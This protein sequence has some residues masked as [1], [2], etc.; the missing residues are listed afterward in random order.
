[1]SQK[2]FQKIK[3]KIKSAKE[4]AI[5]SHFEQDGD[6]LGSMIALSLALKQLKKKNLI[7]AASFPEEYNWLIKS[8]NIVKKVPKHFKPDVVFVLDS[9]DLGRV[10][11]K[12]LFSSE[13]FV[14]NIDHHMDNVHFGNINFVRDTS[15]VGEMIFPLLKYLKIKTTLNI[16]EAIYVAIMTDTGGFRF[17]NTK[18]TTFR[19]AAQLVVKGVKPYEVVKKVYESRN[20][21]ELDVYK[22]AL[23]NISYK[24]RGKIVY[25]KLASASK[26][27][28]RRVIDFIRTIK[29][30][31]VVLVF[32][33]LNKDLV[34]VSLRSK[35]KVDVNRIAKIFGGGGH[36]QAS[37]C[38]V[39]G[40][41]KEV[42][43]KVLKKTRK[44]IGSRRL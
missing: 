2:I 1:M 8:V 36:S 31:E 29:G 22:E 6:S 44:A 30:T 43:R 13:P 14:I 32:K 41:E 26:M 17:A 23:K 37:G 4:I 3:K 40:R 19:I 39:K 20:V 9:S 34:K 16:A 15:S 11:M 10:N 12:S 7:F 28:A 27:E 38:I 35:G 33:S 24:G 5:V 42:I 18:E 25:T 21:K